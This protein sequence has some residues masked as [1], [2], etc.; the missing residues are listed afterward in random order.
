MDIPI[1]YRTNRSQ[2]LNPIANNLGI[3][4]KQFRNK[5]L[6]VDEINRVR[7]LPRSNRC[8]NDKDPCT[9]QP[10]DD[11]DDEYFVE[12]NQFDRH[13]GADARSLKKMFETNNHVLPWSIDFSSGI[14]AS[15]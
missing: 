10:I 3:D 12:W 9:M 7:C 6:L 5:K 2:I 8:Y 13:F 11:I 4:Y 14:Q 1:S 15:V